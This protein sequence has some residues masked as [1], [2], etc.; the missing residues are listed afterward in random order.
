MNGDPVLQTDMQLLQRDDENRSQESKVALVFVD[1][2]DGRLQKL[3]DNFS[4]KKN[5]LIQSE[6]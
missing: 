1:S 3:G 5:L 4:K 2:N 6:T